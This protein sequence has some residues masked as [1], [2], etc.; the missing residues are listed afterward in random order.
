MAKNNKPKSSKGT[1]SK[2]SNKSTPNKTNSKQTKKKM[3]NEKTVSDLEDDDDAS[4]ASSKTNENATNET[5]PAIE[6]DDEMTPA[7]VVPPPPTDTND[8]AS[9]T[10]AAVVAPPATNIPSPNA[11]INDKDNENAAIDD[12]NNENAANEKL[13]AIE[14]NDETHV[15]PPPTNASTTPAAVV[16]PPATNI[17]PNNAGIND[18]DKS[19]LIATDPSNMTPVTETCPAPLATNKD[20]ERGGKTERITKTGISVSAFT[21][22][23]P[24]FK[25]DQDNKYRAI[26]VRGNYNI[27]KSDITYSMTNSIMGNPFQMV[28]CGQKKDFDN[29]DLE[30][31][32]YR[33]SKIS[34]NK[35]SFY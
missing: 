6:N 28:Q 7:A 19:E 30:V 9:A 11:G 3:A 20:K 5:V 27:L 8:K 32:V 35:V 14:N 13:P 26:N 16:A 10:P 4:T 15:P 12:K 1:T 24:L 29:S 25:S 18:K 23:L 34:K 31:F 33:Y 17:P 22:F 21:T 2:G